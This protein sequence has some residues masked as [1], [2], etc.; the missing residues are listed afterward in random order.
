[1]LRPKQ[2]T[3]S[4]IHPKNPSG[5]IFSSLD[6]ERLEMIT[7]NTVIIIITHFIFEQDFFLLAPRDPGVAYGN[8]A[9]YGSIW[10]HMAAKQPYGTYTSY[11]VVN[12]SYMAIW[13]VWHS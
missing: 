11:I 7:D 2:K 8:M 3:S 1:M 9:A 4:L 6:M 12:G 10:Q 13:Q 5:T